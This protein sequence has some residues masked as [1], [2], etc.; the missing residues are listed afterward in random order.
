MNTTTFF[1]N[2]HNTERKS[3]N[4]SRINGFILCALLLFM[5][6]APLLSVDASGWLWRSRATPKVK[7]RREGNND[8]ALSMPASHTN[9]D[10]S[11]NKTGGNNASGPNIT[12]APGSALNKK[13]SIDGFVMVDSDPPPA[14]ASESVGSVTKGVAASVE[15]VAFQP[16]KKENVVNPLIPTP[17]EEKRPTE[18]ASENDQEAKNE[19]FWLQMKASLEVLEAEM[20]AS[21]GNFDL[22]ND[23]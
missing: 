10:H 12:V 17:S 7:Y 2:I 1:L 5:I 21:R 11:L 20:R 8:V 6:T 16:P 23:N 15:P 4:K 14:H 22:F 18:S 9:L 3:A 13:S 19:E